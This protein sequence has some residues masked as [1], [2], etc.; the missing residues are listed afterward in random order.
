VTTS[1]IVIDLE[2]IKALPEAEQVEELARV[3]KLQSIMAGNPLWSWIYHQGAYGY[4]IEHG[5][6]LDGTEDEGQKTFMGMTRRGVY[7]GAAVAGNR[8]GKTEISIVDAIVQTLPWELVPPWLSEFKVL[9]PAKRDIRMR[10]GGADEARWLY[11]NVLPKLRRLIPKAALWGESFEKAWQEKRHILTFK[12]GST[13]DFLTYNMDLQAWSGSDLDRISFDE[14]PLGRHGEAIHEESVGRLADRNGQFR[15]TL[16]P[17]EGIGWLYYLLSDEKGEPRKDDEVYVVRGDI[18]HNPHI[19]EQGRKRA[20]REWERKDPMRV[21]AR[22]HGRWVHLEGAIFPEFKRTPEEEGGH[23]CADRPPPEGAAIMAVFDPGIDDDHPFALHLAFIDPLDKGYEVF[24][25]HRIYGGTA[26]EMADHY[27]EALAL[28]SIPRGRPRRLIDP[29]ARN[30]KADTGRSM[31]WYLQRL[32]INTRPGKNDRMIS[33][34][35]IKH[36]LK[37]RHEETGRYL[38]RIQ[39]SCDGDLGDEMVNY[40]WKKPRTRTDN[41]P[42]Q[43]PEP[44]KIKDDLIDTVRYG[45]MDVRLTDSNPSETVPEEEGMNGVIRRHIKSLA[46]R[47]KRGRVGGY[48]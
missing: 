34:S 2:R 32:G 18:D 20:I 28:Y 3:Q 1:P 8:F 44:V 42:T 19:S 33:Y 12:D 5:I 46:S 39:A 6:P 26:Q 27:H 21:E 43:R 7:H 10:F 16:T 29:I 38:L 41:E 45:V 47:S 17:V 40:R 30:R 22:R 25:T 35:E 36:R 24:H 13:W 15:Y 9:D 23:I 37:T 11:Q 31:Q 14:E 4:K 48:W